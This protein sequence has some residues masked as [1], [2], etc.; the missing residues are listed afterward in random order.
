[1]KKEKKKEYLKEVSD[2]LQ[3]N[4]FFAQV[5]TNDI[6]SNLLTQ[7]KK[8]LIKKGLIVKHVMVNLITKLELKPY[9][10]TS[11]LI[12]SKEKDKLIETLKQVDL[13]SYTFYK[14]KDLAET[15]INIKK[16]ALKVKPIPHLELF[17][18]CMKIKITK[19][20]LEVLEDTLL[21]KKNTPVSLEVSKILNV[22]DRKEKY[23]GIK[24]VKL[25]T[26]DTDYCSNW[27]EY[28]FYKS[29]EELLANIFKAF[30]NLQNN[31][32]I[33]IVA[34]TAKVCYVLATINK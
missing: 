26:A 18:K 28:T 25:G 30:L 13:E 21:V 22:L 17:E 23:R 29:K 19:G 1:M 7:L 10:G 14:T 20:F 5:S 16:G 31:T 34:R 33:D 9:K 2:L 15:D 27:I 11:I 12:F 8:Y 4:A 32:K 3:N 24:I 6:P